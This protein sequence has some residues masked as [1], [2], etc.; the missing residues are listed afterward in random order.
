MFEKIVD[1]VL[2]N[3]GEGHRYAPGEEPAFFQ[4]ALAWAYTVEIRWVEVVWFLAFVILVYLVFR[5]LRYAWIL[6]RPRR[7]K[8]DDEEIDAEIADER[9]RR[10]RLLLKTRMEADGKFNF[11][12]PQPAR[13]RRLR[14]RTVP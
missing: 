13:R 3:L 5:A 8:V 1:D 4:K 6:T 14:S 9:A 12:Q 11:D 2:R 7:R 10:Y